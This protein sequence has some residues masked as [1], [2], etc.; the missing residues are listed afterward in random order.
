M[1]GS[2]R[3]SCSSQASRALTQSFSTAVVVGFRSLLTCFQRTHQSQQSI[4]REGIL[5]AVL[6]RSRSSLWQRHLVINCTSFST[7]RVPIRE[8]SLTLLISKSRSQSSPSGDGYRRRGCGCTML[9]LS[10][11]LRV[12]YPVQGRRLALRQVAPRGAHL[13]C[14]SSVRAWVRPANDRNLVFSQFFFFVHR[15]TP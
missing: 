1:H 12:V 10:Q 14:S 3:P 9:R 2:F 15:W 5:P 4:R 13:H 7:V 11:S 6:S 8:H